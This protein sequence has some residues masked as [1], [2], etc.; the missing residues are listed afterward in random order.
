MNIVTELEKHQSVTIKNKIMRY[1]GTDP[2]RFDEL[3]KIFLGDKYRLTQ[4]AGWPLSDIVGRHPELI[5]PYLKK[6]LQSIDRPDQHVAVKRNVMRIFQFIEIPKSLRGLAF[7]KAFKLYSDSGE[8]TAVRIFSMTVMAQVAMTEPEL[9]NEVILA[10]EEQLP[11]A[12]AGFKARAKRLLK[13]MTKVTR[14][15]R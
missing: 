5:R 13:E 9:K 7:D 4:W 3:V 2:N 15:R 12:S 8:P 10:I 14:G 6:I 1:V 11:Y